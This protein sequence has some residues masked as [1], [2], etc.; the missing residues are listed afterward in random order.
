MHVCDA[1]FHFRTMVGAVVLFTLLPVWVACSGEGNI[2]LL[3]DEVAVALKA[4]TYPDDTVLP[5]EPVSKERQRRSDDESYDG[6]PRIDSNM[7]G[8]QRY[9]HERRNNNDSG[10]QMSIINATDYDYEGYGTGS[11]GE[12]L[13][14]SIPRPAA[15]NNNINNNNTSRT[16]RS[17]PLLNKPDTDQVQLNNDCH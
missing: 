15:V 1:N 11:M 3:E 4:C 6:S 10:D 12:K 13:L 2:K 8:G 7:K 16:R 9:S 5:K 14:T 17:E